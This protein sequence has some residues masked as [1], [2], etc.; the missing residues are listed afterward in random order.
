MT[1]IYKPVLYL[2]MPQLADPN[3]HKAV[4]LMLHHAAEGAMGLV[5]NRT[6]DLSLATFAESQGLSCPPLLKHAPVFAGG[7]VE[8][9]R[10]FVLHTR[11]DIEDSQE[12]IPEVFL[13]GS[14][15]ALTHLLKDGEP[16]VNLVLG[17]AGWG[18]GQLEFELTQGAWLT[19]PV[20]FR[21][22]FEMEPQTMWEK[23]LRGMGIDPA[24]LTH[25][26]GVH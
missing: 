16:P 7:P 26:S 6:L 23:V 19:A 20:S 15:N 12:I 1:P 21:E 10:G 2:A 5:I 11:D 13:S 4:V 3:F 22:I 8:Q 17:Y 24:M 25:A 9:Q 18:A 14:T